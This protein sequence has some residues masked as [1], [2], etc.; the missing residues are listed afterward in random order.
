METTTLLARNHPRHL[1]P[2][3]FTGMRDV[4]R[5]RYDDMYILSETFASQTAVKRRSHINHYDLI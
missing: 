4:I 5:P 3:G 1:L 2:L